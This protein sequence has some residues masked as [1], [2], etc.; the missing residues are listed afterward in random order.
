MRDYKD[1]NATPWSS[2]RKYIN[3]IIIS[4]GIT[5]VGNFAFSTCAL[6]EAVSLP[7]GIESIGRNSFELTYLTQL[8]LPETILRI[9]ESAF[10]FCYYLSHINFPNSLKRI[11]EEAF[12]VCWS[13]KEAFLPEGLSYIG[14][15]A[16][17]SAGSQSSGLAYRIPEGLSYL[18]TGVF[19]AS[20]I[21]E[22]VLPEDITKIPDFTFGGCTKLSSITIPA[23]VNEIGRG[24]FNYSI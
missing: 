21:V 2:Y 7:D 14:D 8:H 18:G 6:K 17:F 4:P 23:T 11:E 9:E 3:S 13:L 12:Y 19:E 22:V 16:F 1:E 20:G 10:A 5:R 15:R 24:A